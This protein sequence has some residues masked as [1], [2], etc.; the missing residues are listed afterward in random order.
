M[1]LSLAV[2]NHFIVTTK[3][4]SVAQIIKNIGYKA[5]RKS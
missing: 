3:K 2:E 4:T 5:P 1:N